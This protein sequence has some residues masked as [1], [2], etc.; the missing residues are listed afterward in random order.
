[1]SVAENIMTKGQYAEICLT[2]PVLQLTLSL[3]LVEAPIITIL[4]FSTAAAIASSV[5]P[6]AKY[7]R[8]VEMCPKRNAQEHALEA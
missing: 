7:E 6:P 2:I 3:Y 8:R 5:E 4:A 1:M